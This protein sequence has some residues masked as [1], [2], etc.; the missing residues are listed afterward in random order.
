MGK[1]RR[2]GAGRKRKP[3][4]FE[5]YTTYERCPDC[6]LRNALDIVGR[7][8]FDTV[9]G[10]PLTMDCEGCKDENGRSTGRVARTR[11]VDPYLDRREP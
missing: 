1:K 10:I 7:P 9:M 2:K 6:D 4:G 5:I 3:A 8:V 11:V